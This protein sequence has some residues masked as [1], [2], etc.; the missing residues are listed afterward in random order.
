MYKRVDSSSLLV[1]VSRGFKGCGNAV[2]V[3]HRDNYD[4]G[5]VASLTI[6]RVSNVSSVV[7]KLSKVYDNMYI[8]GFWVRQ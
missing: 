5:F 3:L 8:T 6:Q 1:A 2:V 4:K 7:N